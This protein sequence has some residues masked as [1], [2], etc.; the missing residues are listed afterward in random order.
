MKLNFKII[1]I[2]LFTGIGLLGCSTP[3][4]SA[5]TTCAIDIQGQ[6]SEATLTRFSN[7]LNER[8]SAKCNEIAVTLNSGGGKMYVAMTIGELIRSQRLNTVILAGNKCASACGLIFISGV[9]RAL[10]NT[11]FNKSSLGLHQSSLTLKAGKICD[12]SSLA[13]QLFPITGGASKQDKYIKSMLKD[14]AANFY[15]LEMEKADCN[16]VNYLDNLEAYNR[17]IATQVI[18]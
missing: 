3:H 13:T 12:F 1:A 14:D 7:A 16:N 5:S 4:Q 15:I 8:Q 2:I 17:G 9:N 10:T 18:R 6:I 11:A